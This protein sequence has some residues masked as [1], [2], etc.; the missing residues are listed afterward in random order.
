VEK[1]IQKLR[2]DTT[3]QVDSLFLVDV[4]LSATTSETCHSQSHQHQI[5]AT[6]MSTTQRLFTKFWGEK[7]SKFIRF[8]ELIDQAK[9]VMIV[10]VS[11]FF[12]LRGPK[13]GKDSIKGAHE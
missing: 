3:D 4:A 13:D 5:S 10:T 8:N 11:N 1:Q 7:K 9:I 6:T 2:I 12:F